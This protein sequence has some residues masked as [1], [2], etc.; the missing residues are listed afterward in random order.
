MMQ[1]IDIVKGF[2]KF[3]G[4]EDALLLIY[5]DS[6]TQSAL[7]VCNLKE[8]PEA[9]NFAVARLAVIE[10]KTAM[11]LES[12][13]Q[14]QSEI[15]AEENGIPERKIASISESGG[16][17]SFDTSGDK[18]LI[19]AK[20]AILDTLHKLN[21]NTVSINKEFNKFKKPYR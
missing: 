15:D 7:N 12:L 21:E 20:K 1:I 2:L 16:S 19:S 18:D 8:L 13:D 5:V 10:Y 3:D 17:V 14:I 9:L 4:V 11:A 6:A